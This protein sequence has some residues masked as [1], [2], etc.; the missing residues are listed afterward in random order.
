MQTFLKKELE[1]VFLEVT[2]RIDELNLLREQDKITQK[3]FDELLKIVKKVDKAKDFISKR[4]YMKYIQN[5]FMI[6]VFYRS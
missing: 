3:H 1:K 6:S 5:V 2:P 4:K